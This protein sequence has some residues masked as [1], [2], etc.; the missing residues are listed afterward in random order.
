MTK[1]KNLTAEKVV[2]Y[3]KD[4]FGA[5]IKDA[6]IKKRAAGSK[7]KESATIWMKVDKCVFKK[8]V[9]HLMNLQFPHLAVVSGND[10][11]KTIELIYHFTLNYDI[12]LDE[13]T[14]NI[15]V[16]LPKSKPEIESVCDLI[17]GALVT[18]R[19]KQ[20]MLGVK[21]K[22]IPVDKR[23]FLPD[24]FPDGVYPWRRDKTG[25]EK[26]YKNLHEVKK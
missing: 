4:E 17:P 1:A 11:D 8:V 19:E 26:L 16:D 12:P 15:S 24:D 21:I 22:D 9:K 13:I 20:E 14:L 3:F 7:K 2:K 6:K 18:E 25:P 23:L 10:L 5:K